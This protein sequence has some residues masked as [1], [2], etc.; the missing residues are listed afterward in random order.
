MT[1]PP[2][3]AVTSTVSALSISVTLPVRVGQQGVA[4]AESAGSGIVVLNGRLD[5]VEAPKLRA[6]LAGMRAAGAATVIIDLADVHFIDSAGLAALVR[7]RKDARIIGG[8]IVL[9]RPTDPDALR[10]FRLTQFD[11][12][13]CMV[14]ARPDAA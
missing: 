13:F 9:V 8:D 10:V 6:E 5:A 11:R 7:A 2:R 14:D 4:A 1:I 12:V 3:H